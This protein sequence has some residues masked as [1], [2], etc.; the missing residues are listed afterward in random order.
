MLAI[1]ECLALWDFWHLW[2]PFIIRLVQGQVHGE[3]GRAQT[4][5]LPVSHQKRRERSV[6][7]PVPEPGT[8]VR[9]EVF[10]VG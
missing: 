7:G 5:R 1:K 8:A 3:A 6:D 2:H 10:G 4:L 9:G